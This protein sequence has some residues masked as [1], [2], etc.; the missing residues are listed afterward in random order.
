MIRYNLETIAKENHY[1]K[2]FT[3]INYKSIS[4]LIILNA[5]TNSLN[6]DQYNNHQKMKIKQGGEHEKLTHFLLKKM[7][8]D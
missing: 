4:T 7:A 5:S 3:V 1:P 6:T 8:Q 2:K